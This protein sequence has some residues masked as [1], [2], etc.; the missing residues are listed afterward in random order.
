[1][2]A[3]ANQKR[4]WAQKQLNIVLENDKEDQQQHDLKEKLNVVEDDNDDYEDLE[5]MKSGKNC[6]LCLRT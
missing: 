4:N 1:M 3:V 5:T 2:N 6:H